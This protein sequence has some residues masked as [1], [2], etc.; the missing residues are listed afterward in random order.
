MFN[1]RVTTQAQMFSKIYRLDGKVPAGF[2]VNRAAFFA[3][4]ADNAK[5]LL[6]EYGVEV[7]SGATYDECI[8]FLAC[9]IGVVFPA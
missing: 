4:S 9:H 2:P 3:L 5:N 1:L 7:A 6:A 8:G